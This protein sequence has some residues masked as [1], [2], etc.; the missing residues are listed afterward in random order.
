[1]ADRFGDIQFSTETVA[2]SPE[3]RFSGIEFSVPEGRGKAIESVDFSSGEKERFADVEFDGKK[4]E[5]VAAFE[6]R[7]GVAPPAGEQQ[8]KPTPDTTPPASGEAAPITQT[9]PLGAIAGAVSGAMEGAGERQA[10]LEQEG[11]TGAQQAAIAETGAPA[12]TQA[13]PISR[14]TDIRARV[15]DRL[16]QL[17][18]NSAQRM[19]LEDAAN[20]ITGLIGRQQELQMESPAGVVGE[21][22]A[23]RAGRTLAAPVVGAAKAGTGLF[24]AA[25]GFL[26]FIGNRIPGKKNVLNRI[27]DSVYNWAKGN[28]K[29]IEQ[30]APTRQVTRNPEVLLDPAWWAEEASKAFTSVSQAVIGGG[31]T[32]KG[33]AL[34]GSLLE[35]APF[36]KEIQGEEGV[37]E[38][39]AALKAA[40][41]GVVVAML[42]K[43]GL[44]KI[45]AGTKGAKAL[46]V[47]G[48]TE[49]LTEAG[50]EPAGKIIENIGRKSPFK[51]E[52]WK[53]A[54]SA[55]IDGINAMP[56]AFL[57]GGG[58]GAT[59]ARTVGDR[60]VA[61]RQ[62]GPAQEHI[63]PTEAAFG[64]RVRAPR[65]VKEARELIQTSQHPV[66]KLMSALV[67]NKAELPARKLARSEELSR[68]VAEVEKAFQQGEGTEAI[69]QA[70][71]ALE[72]ELP[73]AEREPV[74]RFFTTPEREAFIT[75]IAR[76]RGGLTPFDR[77][78][79]A[80]GISRMMNGQPLRQFEIDALGKIFGKDF[81]KAARPPTLLG[82][83]GGAVVQSA[84]FLR[85]LKTM[86][87]L[88][89]MGR[90]G[91]MLGPRHAKQYGRA[92][93]AMKEGVFDQ[94]NY[95][96]LHK[97]ITTDPRHA[98]R[99]A[100]GLYV[101]PVREEGQALTE[102]EEAFMSDWAEKIPG[103]K[104]SERAFNGFLNTLRVDAFDK[105]VDKWGD[106]ATAEDYQKWAEFINA[107]TGRGDLNR[108]NKNFE[109]AMPAMASVFFSPRWVLSRIQAPLRAITPVRDAE[110]GKLRWSPANTEAIKSMGAYYGMM[111]TVLALARA[112]GAEV[113]DDPRS[114]DFA[115]IKIGNTRVDL[116]AG[117]QQYWRFLGQ[118][119]SG[120]RKSLST[121]KI[122]P[123]DREKQVGR[124]IR[125]KLAPAPGLILSAMT[126]K[127]FIGD[128]FIPTGDED[129]AQAISKF[130]RNAGAPE[131]VARGV[132][133][134][135][136][137]ALRELAPLIIQQTIEG[138]QSD[139]LWGGL[140]SGSGEFVGVST[141]S[142]KPRTQR[143]RGRRRRSRRRRSRRRSR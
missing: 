83:A 115:K 39:E 15:R 49:A 56:G 45:F 4:P 61:P 14:L 19:V 100:S 131:S 7:I 40:G 55:A 79:A 122:S 9:G 16:I 99:S 2:E 102:R 82:R 95:E 138:M 114:S 101:A 25:G 68:R 91:A 17:P 88:S 65:N 136:E 47:K 85:T 97:A 119:I 86:L 90:Q 60:V 108:I 58:M 77:L 118:M 52:F 96:R 110:T 26:D 22:L 132:A 92:L 44:D 109:K 123:A 53:D 134:T 106:A 117:M 41:Y 57:V 30:V 35:A 48:L 70:K 137:V 104:M 125:S 6:Q 135:G 94:E 84:G 80:D 66:E 116:S 59:G 129:T 50:E 32:L 12:P 13:D 67:I 105:M 78:T 124:F 46:A 1:M 36:Y 76:K 143:G 103:A 87:D 133:K 81:A 43:I 34:V 10:L 113:E 89:A 107:A 51:S 24:E 33:A 73:T 72:G 128:E 126:G 18:K 111:L 28:R 69:I 74:E 29:L 21:E 23:A 8:E 20:S 42:E 5:H 120:K 54:L 141:S 63:S 130:L 27:G 75:E 112:G 142:F 140:L 62:P 37:G 98:L 38:T 64:E 31:K 93:K 139:G 11:P 3:G 71:R 121:G 127:T